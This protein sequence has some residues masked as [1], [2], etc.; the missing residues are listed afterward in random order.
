MLDAQN[1]LWALPKVH[2]LKEVYVAADVRISS[3]RGAIAQVHE[4]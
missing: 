3:C 2:E 1:I 4:H